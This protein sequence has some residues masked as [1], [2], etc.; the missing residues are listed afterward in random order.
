MKIAQRIF[1]L[2]CLVVLA[3]VGIAQDLRRS[4]FFGVVTS[5][6]TEQDQAKLP[7]GAT[8][9]R[10]Q[11]VID[12]S[13]AKDA[14]ARSDDIIVQVN[15]HKIAGVSD[16]L[17]TVR[18]FHGGDKVTV[19]LFRNGQ[20]LRK[21]VTIKPRPF[22]SAPDV[23][24]LY[25]VVSVDGSLRRV[26]VTV[27]KTSGKHP[28][29]L[30]VNGIGCY[31]QESSDLSSNDAKLLYGLTRAGFV[32]M[33]VEKSGMGDSEGPPCASSA[34]DLSAERRGYVAG[35]KELMQY[36]FVDVDKIFLVG[37]SI[38][39][40]QAPLIAEEVPVKGIVVINT[41]IKPFFEYLI[42]TR[43]RQN[44]LS[45]LP[46]DEIDRHA[47]LNEKCNHRLLVEK[48]SFDEIVKSIPE[49][50][51]YITY[52]AASSY[53]QQWADLN[54]SNE[55]KKVSAPV[56]IVYGTADYVSTIAD[57]PLLASVINSFH[58]GHATLIEIANMDHTMNKAA[59]MEESMNWPTEKPR[60]FQSGV[61]TEISTW[62]KQQVK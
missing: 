23:D 36:P 24:T 5:E 4:G 43:R 62:L 44:A 54:L 33:R 10:V 7:K 50:R 29:V 37:I 31:T 20:E 6:L 13:S 8:G 3:G 48:Q 49:C 9:I 35:L 40:V 30:Y 45:R 27:P 19:A 56:L 38:G 41:V 28:A 42:D 26:I 21:Q 39:G 51:D 15:E 22:E 16:F 46:F 52:P 14:D 47:I 25:K 59:S 61:L 57:D 58:P 18:R 2:A 1:M 12:G 53:M 17:E 32:T 55:W 34:V 60:E 11:R